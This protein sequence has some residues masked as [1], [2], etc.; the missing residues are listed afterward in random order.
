MEELLL[1]QKTYDG[2]LEWNNAGWTGKG[3]NVWNMEN[4]NARHGKTST[5]RIKQAAPDANVFTLTHFG[6]FKNGKVVEEHVEGYGSADNFIKTENIR[7]SSKS[8][9]QFLLMASAQKSGQKY[10]EIGV[11]WHP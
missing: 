9:P 8:V 4:L 3:V 11:L 2:T 5:E 1:K 10:W 7:R 6:S